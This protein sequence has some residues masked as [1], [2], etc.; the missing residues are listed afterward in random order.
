MTGSVAVDIAI[1]LIF[2]FLL[3]S[4]LASIVQEIIATL[5]GLRARNL[6]HAIRRM[7]Q[8]DNVNNN[9]K[10][11]RVSTSIK[12]KL[13]LNDFDKG[14]TLLKAFYEQPMIK[15]LASGKFFSKPSYIGGSD[16]SEAL[17]KILKN[18]ESDLKELDKRIEEAIV[19]SELIDEETRTHLKALWDNA[20]NDINKFKASLE[21]WFNNTMERAAGWYKRS[22]QFTLLIIGFVMATVFHVNTLEIVNILSNDQSVRK[23][24]VQLAVSSTDSDEFKNTLENLKNQTNKGTDS[25]NLDGIQ[26][27][28]D[29]LFGVYASLKLEAEKANNVMGYNV[30]DS[31]GIVGSKLDSTEI[32]MK[33]KELPPNQKIIGGYVVNF[34]SI[35]LANK[36]ASFYEITEHKKS[37][38]D[39]NPKYYADLKWFSFFFHN[40]WGYLITALAISLGAPFWFDLLSKIVKVRSSLQ[41]MAVGSQQP[42]TQQQNTPS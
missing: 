30:P 22:T 15:Y 8:D 2:V 29:S 28:V 6:K 39:K 34:P 38:K 7:L 19:K 25:L 11:G 35:F 13:H 17:M 32:A 10:A 31:L 9:T 16:F 23:E 14:D 33:A 4:L 26:T 42:Q 3:Y 5:L 40:F 41:K 12:K 18:H 27:R 24:M 36:T 1:G 37:K 21:G 20:E